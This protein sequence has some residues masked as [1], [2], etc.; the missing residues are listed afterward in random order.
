MATDAP[1]RRWTS[2]TA[3]LTERERETAADKRLYVE[4]GLNPVTCSSCGVEALVKK[5][6]RKHTSVQWTAAAVAA[7]REISAMRAADRSALV[8]GCPRMMASIEDAVRQ[9]AVVVPDA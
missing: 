7:C 2:E 8:L 9:G 4:I 5:N 6:S 1:A 3:G